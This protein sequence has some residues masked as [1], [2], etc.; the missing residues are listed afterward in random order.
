[1][2]YLYHS[3]SETQ[4]RAAFWKMKNVWVKRGECRWIPRFEDKTNEGKYYILN[5]NKERIGECSW[6][7]VPFSS[8][9]LK[10]KEKL[11]QQSRKHAGPAVIDREFEGRMKS[12]PSRLHLHPILETIALHLEE[13]IFYCS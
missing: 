11:W 9:T 13:V 2:A 1:M 4:Q 3:Q 5:D 12:L 8:V 10:E 7:Y 6:E